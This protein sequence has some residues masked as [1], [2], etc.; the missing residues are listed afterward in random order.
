MQWLLGGLCPWKALLAL[1]M[2]VDGS[3]NQQ[4][5]DFSTFHCQIVNFTLENS[6]LQ[7]MR[8]H[9]SPLQAILSDHEGWNYFFLYTVVKFNYTA[10]FVLPDGENLKE[11]ASLH[12]L[13]SAV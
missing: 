11:V 13:T 5:G 10:G 12:Q 7:C 2:F 6:Q 1:S 9:G 8:Q 4:I 3:S